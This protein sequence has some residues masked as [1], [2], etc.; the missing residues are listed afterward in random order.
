MPSVMLHQT[1]V[2][3]TNIFCIGRNYAEHIAELQ[4]SRDQEMP[5]FL[6]PTSALLRGENTIRLPEYSNNVHYECE[7]VLLIGQD[8][9]QLNRD[10]ALACVAG[11][12]IGLDLTARDVQNIAKEKGLP[13]L[14]AK[15]FRHA[16]CVSDFV[17]PQALP[18]IGDV[19]FTLDVNGEIRQ[20]GHTADM[21][22][23]VPEIL[24][25]L[26]H[27]YGL[28]AGDIVFTGTPQGVGALHAGDVLTLDLNGVI[29]TH[30]KVA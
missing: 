29:G 2:E 17:A 27:T 1:T 24:V 22:Y 11:Y 10:Q 7:L 13:W 18:E 8:A 19:H 4:H 28:Q 12:G 15:G 21:L 9:A 14:K 30:F 23:D 20:R 25:F 16:A 6:K 26:A 3:V 5:V